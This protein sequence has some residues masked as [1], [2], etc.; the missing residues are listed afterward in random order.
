MK[1]FTVLIVEADPLT[2]RTVAEFLDRSIYDLTLVEDALPA[3][4]YVQNQ[5]LPHIALIGLELPSESGFAVANRLKSRAD[6]P[7]IFM[8]PAGNKAVIIEQLKMYADDFVVMP[9]ELRELETRMQMVLA[10][11]PAIDYGTE[12]VLRVDEHLSIDFAHNRVL[13]AG[14][15]VGL[16]P[17]ESALLHVLLRSAP[18]VVQTQSLLSRVWSREEVF[19]DTLRVHM[20]RLRRKIELDSHHPYYLRTERGVGYRFHRRP[21]SLSEDAD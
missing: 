2:S 20:H 16:T 9:F 8:I 21:P 4:E 7:I 5:G 14:K 17:I 3:I 6:V 11:M 1:R 10:R 19:E 13:V 18:R 15:T 12:P